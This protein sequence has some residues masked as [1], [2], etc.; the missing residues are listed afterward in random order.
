MGAATP[1]SASTVKGAACQALDKL[2]LD[3]AALSRLQTALI[4]ISA[5]KFDGLQDVLAQ[6]LLPARKPAYTAT[7]IEGIRTHLKECWFDAASPTCYFPRVP[8]AEIY[9]A[10]IL[11]T[12][13]LSLDG[14][15]PIDSWW[16]L[17]H[18]AVDMMN[19]ATPRQVTLIIATPRPAAGG[20]DMRL[21]ADRAE[22]AVG[23]LSTRFIG[24]TVQNQK[25]EIPDR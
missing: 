23:G 17:D 21:L 13:S 2:S 11:Q 8:V 4:G 16:A 24:G 19:F 5:A 15:R 10:G 7:Q 14:N 25:L 3:R 6:H 9:G 18:G 1:P 12:V 20:A 22:P